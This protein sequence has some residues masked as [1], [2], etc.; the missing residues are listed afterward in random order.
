M[1]GCLAWFAA[2]LALFWGYMMHGVTFPLSYSYPDLCTLTRAHT[3]THTHTHTH[4][5]MHTRAH[6]HTHTQFQEVESGQAK[7]FTLPLFNSLGRSVS[8]TQVN[9]S[10]RRFSASYSHPS[11]TSDL[12][13]SPPLSPYYYSGSRTLYMPHA[14]RRQRRASLVGHRSTV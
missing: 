5:H 4:M 10:P 9:T 6:T 13:I 12:S 8:T 11:S 2:N 7:K 3:H 14:N 1:G